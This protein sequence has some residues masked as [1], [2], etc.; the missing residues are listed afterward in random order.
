MQVV[1]RGSGGAAEGSCRHHR[2]TGA[3][4]RPPIAIGA[5]LILGAVAAV[6][7]IAA[8]PASAL[9]DWHGPI[10]RALFPAL[11]ATN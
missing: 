7:I 4:L 10:C 8:A 11:S 6:A 2:G 3:V 5:G 1:L 9:Q